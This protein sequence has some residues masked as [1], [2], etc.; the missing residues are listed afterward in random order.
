MFRGMKI[1]VHAKAGAKEERVV[2]PEPQ[3]MPDEL[4]V[5][6][7]HVKEPAKEGKANAG[8]ARALARHFG[9]SE[10]QVHLLSGATSRHKI[11]KIE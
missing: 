8:I 7:V 11:F 10:S 3:L 5:Y 6:K 9:I 4:P 2:P 1:K